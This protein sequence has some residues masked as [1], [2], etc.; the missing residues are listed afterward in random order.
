[1]EGALRSLA[2]ELGLKVG[3]LLGS[4]RIATTGLRVSPPLFETIALLGRERSLA[5]IRAGANRL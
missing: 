3:Q 4:L 5:A 1:V 2:A